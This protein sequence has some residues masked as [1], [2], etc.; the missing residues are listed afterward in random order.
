MTTPP[1]WLCQMPVT[2]AALHA[3]EV[4]RGLIPDGDNH[5]DIGFSDGKPD[6]DY[7]ALTDMHVAAALSLVSAAAFQ[8]ELMYGVYG[9]TT[10]DNSESALL[11]D[12]L[13]SFNAHSRQ[14]LR[15]E[16]DGHVL[17]GMTSG[18]IRVYR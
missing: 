2:P 4:L 1:S 10:S 18:S 3:V 6:A 8:H 7:Q 14:T 5:I 11:R 16:V 12:A 13:A 17:H 15:I 9:E